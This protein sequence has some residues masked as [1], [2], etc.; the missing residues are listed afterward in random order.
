[1]KADKLIKGL[2][3]S[4]RDGE[5]LKLYWTIERNISFDVLTNKK[6]VYLSWFRNRQDDSDFNQEEIDPRNCWFKEEVD[7]HRLIEDQFKM[8]IRR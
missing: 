1:M 6:L 2:A 3:S 7:V 8:N 4:L 5:R